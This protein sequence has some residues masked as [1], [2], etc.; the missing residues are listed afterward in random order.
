MAVQFSRWLSVALIVVGLIV[1]QCA[2]RGWMPYPALPLR[3]S[4]ARDGARAVRPRFL[5]D[6]AV[7]TVAVAYLG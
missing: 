7:T 1:F 3:S 2:Q 6:V 4:L 5:L